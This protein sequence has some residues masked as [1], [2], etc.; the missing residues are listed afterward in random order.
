MHINAKCALL[1][2]NGEP[3][4]PTITDT[5]QT[6]RKSMT[7]GFNQHIKKG[8][9]DCYD[10]DY[11]PP[12]CYANVSWRDKSSRVTKCGNCESTLTGKHG[13]S[14]HKLSP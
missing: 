7:M 2:F 14:I 10:L 5:N 6:N 12:Q 8:Q 13:L 1:F 4:P 11:T 9:H 3:H